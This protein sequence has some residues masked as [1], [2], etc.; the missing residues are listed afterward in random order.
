VLVADQANPVKIST[1]GGNFTLTVEKAPGQPMES[2]TCYL[3]TEAGSYL[4]HTTTTNGQGEAPFELA[5]GTYKIRTDYLGY[6]FWTPVFTVPD[7]G[8]LTHTIAH[9]DV[10]ITVEKQ[11]GAVSEAIEG[12]KVYLFTSSGSYQG[13]NSTTDAEGQVTFSLPDTDYK[14]RADYLSG[15]YWSEVFNQAA[16]A[17]T[18]SE[19]TASITLSSGGTDLEGVQVYVFTASGSYLGIKGITDA[20]GLVEFVLPVGDY[21]F[22]ADYQGSQHWATETVAADQVNLIDMDTGGGTFV[23]TVQK[24]AG[25][26]MVDVPVYVFTQAGSYLG[27]NAR[28]DASGQV[29]FSLPE[30]SYMFRADYLGYK[31][32]SSVSVVS[33][34]LSD[35][36]TID[37]TDVAVSINEVYGVDSDP[38]EGI[39]VY[40]FTESGA[41]QG[42]SAQTDADGHVVFNLPDMAYKVRA[43]YLGG[44]YW[45]QDFTSVDTS[46]D[47]EHG[48]A[49][50]HVTDTGT[51]VVDAPVYLFTEAGSYLG[52]IQRTD[53]GGL[54][55]FLLPAGAYKF[56]VDTNGTQYWSEVVNILADE[57]TTVDLA[58]DLLA[59]DGTRNPHPVR[60][61]GTPPKQEPVMLASLLNITGILNQSV[62]A[63]IGPDAL[64]WFINDHLGTPQKVIDADQAVVW[65]GSQEPSGSTMVSAN[66]LNN[67]FRFPGQYFDT[68][69][70]L[71]YNYHRYYDPSI[72]RYIT[73]DP[74]G[75]NG[76][77]NLFAYANLN[78]IGAIDPYGLIYWRAVGKGAAKV[79]FGVAGVVGGAVAAST[80]TGIG[81]VIG[82]AGALA[83]SSSISFGV[84][85]IITGF[86]D[87]ELAFMGVKEAVI[88]STIFGLTQKNLLAANELLDMI[89]GVVSGRL[90]VDPSKVDEAINF[91]QYGLSIGKSIEQIQEELE[92]KGSLKSNNCE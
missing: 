30:G 52:T 23:L 8:A 32:W 4:G 12:V 86:L 44:Q 72:G 67:N 76:G 36:L 19:G 38:L 79:A 18:V 51:D 17:I 62:V 11:N 83:G 89:P 3:F 26:P 91:I 9:S 13:V 2:V 57:E 15:Q 5:D 80:P 42:Q 82:V 56:R 6:Q 60:F 75:L 47:I 68:E 16:Q 58:L 69:S 25:V 85:Q 74:I 45:S 28:T 78:P 77:I 39:T 81:Q 54:T 34:M 29:S 24:A 92:E 31:F 65:E 48:Y 61:D 49:N 7:T 10:A 41:Y 53:A 71:H 59:M 21:K 22:R 66:T 70:G 14:V 1:G 50:L 37:H 20:G 84:S 40:L 88:Q 33:E 35:A 64:Y 73:P 55:S 46:V 27:I 63:A 90:K 43:D 87:N